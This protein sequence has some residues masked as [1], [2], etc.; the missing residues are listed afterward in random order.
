MSTAKI[1][2]KNLLIILAIVLLYISVLPIKLPGISYIDDIVPL[3]FGGI[4]FLKFNSFVRKSGN[5]NIFLLLCGIC[6]IGGISNLYAGINTEVKTII[7]DMY[8]FLKMFLVYLGTEVILTN[9]EDVVNNLIKKLATLFKAF[10]LLSF[11]C[12]ILTFVG[13]LDMYST[14]R[15]GM[16]NYSFLYNNASQYG[17]LVSVALAFVI[18]ADNKRNII[19]EIMALIV[20]VLT[21]KGMA[22]IVVACYVMLNLVVKR[23]IKIWQIV[24]LGAALAF[25]LRYQIYTYLLNATAPRAILLKYGV[26][27]ANTYFPLGSGFATYG[28]EMAARYYSPLYLMYN[29]TDRKALTYPS[30]GGIYLNDTY[31]GMSFGQF[32]WIGTL[33]LLLVI[34]IIGKKA[35]SLH[36]DNKK[37]KYICIALFACFAG[38]SIMA[39]SIK[40]VPGQVILFTIQV[41][42]VKCRLEEKV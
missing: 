21:L 3:A 35:L 28:S 30:Q 1:Y 15:F 16:P 37:G 14:T 32:G 20:M 10:I 34:Y 13:I 24:L 29:F 9:S 12:G 26:I 36:T 27:T 4:W 5:K 41:F 2:R 19:Y 33:F 22:L 38:M 39:G 18:F 25:V 40:G 7:L 42:F 8:S 17:V 11:V 23:K 31:L 6:I